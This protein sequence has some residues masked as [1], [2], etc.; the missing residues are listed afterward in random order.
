MNKKQY[1]AARNKLRARARNVNDIL[2]EAKR[3]N[4]ANLE[5]LDRWNEYHDEVTE[6]E[7]EIKL[8]DTAFETR[9]W[10]ASMH[11]T[12]NLMAMNID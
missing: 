6:L 3:T 4:G 11:T 2:A 1:T 8:L 10:T 5:N 7:K 12:A 9:N